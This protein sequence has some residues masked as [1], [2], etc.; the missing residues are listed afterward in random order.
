MRTYNT[1]QKGNLA[2]TAISEATLLGRDVI[3]QGANSQAVRSVMNKPTSVFFPT[4]QTP[5]NP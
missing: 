5:T 2:T 4:A 1:W 3:A